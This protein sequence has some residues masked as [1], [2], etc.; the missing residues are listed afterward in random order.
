[1]HISNIT[2]KTK[3]KAGILKEGAFF[4]KLIEESGYL[5]PEIVSRVYNSLIRVIYSEMIMRGGVSLPQF[6]D[7]Y[8][9]R[10][11]SRTTCIH[12][13][14]TVIPEHY[15]IRAIV[16]PSMKKFFKAFAAMNPDKPLDPAGRAGIRPV[17]L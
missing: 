5:E 4:D 16:K 11:K 2:K 13:K 8:F 6:L 10:A 12:R 15:Q 9:S 3:Q 7:I 14:H 17:R 1:M